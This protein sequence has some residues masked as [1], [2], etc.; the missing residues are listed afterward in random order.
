MTSI[1][2]DMTTEEL[3]RQYDQRTLVKNTAP[4]FAQWQADSAATSRRLGAPRQFGYGDRK[5]QFFDLFSPTQEPRGIHVH[6]H[7]GAWRALQSRDA[8]WLAD[9]WVAAGYHFASVNFGLVPDVRLTEQVDHA[10]LALRTI[11]HLMNRMDIRT[12]QELIVSGHSSGAHLAAMA[13]L[14]DYAGTPLARRPDSVILASGIY[15]LEP[16]QLSSR[17]R[18]LELNPEEAVRL[19]PIRRLQARDCTVSVLWSAHELKEFQR[20]SQDLVRALAASGC[21]PLAIESDAP[22]HFQTWPEIGPAAPPIPQE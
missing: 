5:D 8:W 14:T 16:V 20:Q 18:Y 11:P 10:C 4:L 19:S 15:D 2:A 9:D 6:Y 13:A 12:G 3:N 7:G 22:D 17:N 21:T 1:F